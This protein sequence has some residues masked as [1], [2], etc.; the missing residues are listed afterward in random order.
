MCVSN[1]CFQTRAITEKAQTLELRLVYNNNN[2]GS[3]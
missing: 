2:Q 3:V 1:A